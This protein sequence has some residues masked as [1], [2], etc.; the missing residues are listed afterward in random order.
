MYVL[1]GNY[2][3][4]WCCLCGRTARPGAF[5]FLEVVAEGVGAGKV[6]VYCPLCH[7]GGLGSVGCECDL[8]NTTKGG[9]AVPT[10]RMQRRPNLPPALDSRRPL[11][12]AQRSA[13]LC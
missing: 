7:A 3:V 5:H 12:R 6:F 2:L 11:R 1:D 8:L 9:N 4:A 10:L 13:G